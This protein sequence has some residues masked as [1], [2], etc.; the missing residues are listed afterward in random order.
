[1]ENVEIARTLRLVGDLLEIKGRQSVQGEGLSQRGAHDRQPH[2]PALEDVEPGEALDELPGIG[3]DIAGYIEELVRSGHIGRLEELERHVPWTLVDL[4][5]I[6]GVGPK[7]VNAC[8]IGSEFA[9][10]PTW[11]P[12]STRERAVRRLAMDAGLRISEYGVF[13][14]S[15]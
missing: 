1:M 3:H 13:R 9:R 15:K 14:L 4:L 6:E 12:R 8:S 5:R 2:A 11:R 7:R 10:L